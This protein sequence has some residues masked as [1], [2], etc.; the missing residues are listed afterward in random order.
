MAE[1]S[2]QTC[3]RTKQRSPQTMKKLINRLN[4]VEGQIRGIKGMVDNGAYCPDILVQ[5]A[6][7]TAAVNAFARE[8]LSTH[9]RECVTDDIRAGHDETVE[10]LLLVLKKMMK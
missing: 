2:L 10:E 7:V 4:R 9:I 1:K 8:L 3:C 5:C 6:A